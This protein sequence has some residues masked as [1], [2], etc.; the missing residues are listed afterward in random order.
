MKLIKLE[1]TNIGPYKC[2]TIDFDNNN[3]KNITIVCGENGSGKTTI[4]KSIKLGLFGSFLYGYKQNSKSLQYIDEIKSIITNGMTS[5]MISLKFS[6]V[7]DYQESIYELRREWDVSSKFRENI[8]LY[9]NSKLKTKKE[10][11]DTID[12]INHYFSPK[13]IDAM[14]F[15]GEKVIAFIDDDKLNDYVQENIIYSFNLN[16]YLELM[17]DLEKYMNTDLKKANLTVEQI[18]L[19]ELENKLRVEKRNSRLMVEKLNDLRELKMKKDFEIDMLL[20]QFTNLGGIEPDSVSVIKQSLHSLESTKNSQIA[21]VKSFFENKLMYIINRKLIEK[22]YI[23]IEQEKPIRFKEYLLEIKNSSILNN[24]DHKLIDQL[25]KNILSNGI[26]KAIVNLNKKEED[27]FKESYVKLNKYNREFKKI[28]KKKDYNDEIIHELKKSI[29]ISNTLEVQ[30]LF[31]LISNAINDKDQLYIEIEKTLNS[32]MEINN[33]VTDLEFKIQELKAV[34]YEQSK[35]DDSFVMAQKYL[36]VCQE[37]YDSEIERITS[38]VGQ[39]STKLLKSTYRK[40]DYIT[41]I[42]INKDFSINAYS[43]RN[44]KNLKQ[45]SAG[46]KQIFVAAVIVSI[47]KLSKRNLPLVFD[48]PAGRLDNTH[49]DTFY[50]QIMAKAGNQVIILPTSKEINDNVI[51]SINNRISNCYTLEYHTTGNTEII[52]GKI[53]NREWSGK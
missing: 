7:E 41:K 53:F 38:L 32:A 2:N 6:I 33:S 8:T 52:E 30:E 23:Q 44:I 47:I 19:N 31:N 11:I 4:L 28:T 3:Q 12:Y 15:D 35:S 20:N 17:T 42:K 51:K 34:V 39:L 45:L 10:L 16:Y 26:I 24:D 14:M 9:V 27:L 50:K 5:G 37:Y 36:D 22:T 49:M 46:E 40:K 29:E 48:T 43:G 13:L 1:L 25:E 18:Q 21:D